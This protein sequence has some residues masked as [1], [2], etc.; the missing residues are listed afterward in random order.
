MFN[1]LFSRNKGNFAEGMR[2][3][4]I[5]MQAA[6]EFRSNEA[7]DYYT[8]SIEI[9]ANPAPYIN[10]ANLLMK[11]IRCREALNDLLEAKRLDDQQGRQFTA[12]I[13]REMAWAKILSSNY[14]NGIREKLITDLRGSDHRTVAERILCSSFGINHL[15]WEYQTFDRELVEFQLF[16][17]LDDIVKFDDVTVYP[18][19][20]E[21]LRDYDHRFIAMKVAN[22]PNIQSY[23]EAQAKLNNFLCSYDRDDM[24][25]LRR[26]MLYGI[27]SALLAL[28]FGGFYDA[29]DSECT[30]VIR[31]AEDFAAGL[32]A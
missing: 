28:D 8:R 29:L 15:Q 6:V 5:G 32:S 26:Y 30:G 21:L 17:E 4:E 3:F 2:L 11:R 24:I 23:Q 10:R 27:H 12:E 20:E 1:R 16:N 7:I 31:E 13:D 25:L 9:Y 14:D 18:E 19:A 22:C